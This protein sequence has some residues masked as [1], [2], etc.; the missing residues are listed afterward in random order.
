MAEAVSFQILLIIFVVSFNFASANF[1][2]RC[3]PGGIQ[4]SYP[5]AK[6]ALEM[7]KK[8]RNAMTAKTVLQT[9]EL[10]PQLY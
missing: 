2:T 8:S 10:S 9:R 3:V 7:L 5:K 1:Q 6:P 4:V